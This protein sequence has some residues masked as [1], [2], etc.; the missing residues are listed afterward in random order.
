VE[1][2]QGMQNSAPDAGEF[3]TVTIEFEIPIGRPRDD[4]WASIIR[5]SGRWWRTEREGQVR[6]RRIGFSHEFDDPE[7]GDVFEERGREAGTSRLLYTITEIVPMSVIGLAGEIGVHEHGPATTLLRL[8][9]LDAEDGATL[10]HVTSSVFG[11]I[12]AGTEG[13]MRAHAA[14]VFGRALRQYAEA[15]TFRS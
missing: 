4:V 14:E 1:E 12:D 2:N 15:R 13:R 3:G 6:L 9:F 5:E 7:A 11:R 8:E 10:L